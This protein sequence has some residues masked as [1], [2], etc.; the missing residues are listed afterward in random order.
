MI[1]HL[2]VKQF[3]SGFTVMEMLVVL[4]VFS[5]VAVVVIDI[6][7]TITKAYKSL[8]AA[9]AVQ[10][11]MRFTVQTIVKDIQQGLV[12]Y[13]YYESH[14]INLKNNSTGQ[15]EA[16]DTLALIDA[17][18]LPVR[19]KLGTSANDLPTVF[20]CRGTCSSWEQLLSDNIQAPLLN[21]YVVPGSDP[22]SSSG[23]PPNQQPRVTLTMT[24]QAISDSIELQQTSFFIQTTIATRTYKR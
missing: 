3:K 5:V 10:R 23:T 12:D 21:F 19:Y 18:G 6:F 1:M 16:I 9:Q 4:T 8:V 7:F 17:N 11:D 2:S 22:F 20:V 15:V 13:S 14:S 24:G